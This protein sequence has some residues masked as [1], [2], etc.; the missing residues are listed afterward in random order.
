MQH[1]DFVADNHRRVRAVPAPAGLLLRHVLGA[2]SSLAVPSPRAAQ[3]SHVIALARPRPLIEDACALADGQP[4]PRP[5]PG[6][7]RESIL[8]PVQIIAG[9]QKP[10]HVMPVLRPQLDLVEIAVI[11]IE[12]VA[13]LFV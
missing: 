8:C 12:R 9:V 6:V 3:V 11:G 4:R 13:S 1:L 5:L 2:S 7:C 10:E